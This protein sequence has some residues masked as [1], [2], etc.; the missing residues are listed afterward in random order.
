MTKILQTENGQKVDEFEPIY[1]GNSDID[2]KRFA[3]FEHTINRFSFGYIY[4]P[5]L[6]TIFLV[7]HLFFTFF[8]FFLS[9]VAIY[10]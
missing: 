9:S 3:V 7:L 6:K 10:F 4:L 8:R 2:Q 5:Y 1:L